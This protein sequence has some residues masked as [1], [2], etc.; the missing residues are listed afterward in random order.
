MP[1]IRVLTPNMTREQ[2]LAKFSSGGL[3]DYWQVAVY[4]PLRSVADFYIP[5]RL[6]HVEISNG[7]KLDKRIMG[8]DAIGGSLNP[9]HFPTV[10]CAD[11]V[12]SVDTRNYLPVSTDESAAK[13]TVISK[14]Q[15]IFFATGFFRI[16]N[17]EISARQ[18][19][20]AIHVPYWI[21]FRDSGRKVTFTV[22]DAV[23]RQREGGKV[24]L[25]LHR[26]IS[27]H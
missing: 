26:W 9:F 15:R 5:F 12:I 1:T 17:L 16:R 21:G 19:P 24:K 14:L 2:A 7:G 23:R 22:M 11:D 27:S 20:G 18:I 4:G 25:A 13:A 10:P 6:F 3:M 8:V